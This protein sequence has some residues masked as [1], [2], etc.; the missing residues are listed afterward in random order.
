MSTPARK[1]KA[2][3]SQ[4]P[5][6]PTLQ[7]PRLIGYRSWVKHVYDFTRY[8]QDDPDE[9]DQ[10]AYAEW[11]S[12]GSSLTGDLPYLLH[13]VTLETGWNRGLQLGAVEEA[14]RHLYVHDV[15]DLLEFTTDDIR[16]AWAL[17]PQCCGSMEAAAELYALYRVLNGDDEFYAGPTTYLG[18]PDV[19]AIF[20]EPESEEQAVQIDASLSS[21]VHDAGPMVE[22][23]SGAVTGLSL[24]DVCDLTTEGLKAAWANR[25]ESFA[26]LEAAAETLAILRSLNAEDPERPS[27]HRMMQHQLVQELEDALPLE[28][29]AAKPSPTIELALL[30]ADRRTVRN[31]V[32]VIRPGQGNFRAKML[33]R[34]GGECCITGCRVDALI[35]A[36]HIIPYRGDQSDDPTNGL[37]LRVDLHR[38]FDAHLV[39]I[40]PTT[41]TVA[42]AAAL[43]DDG[44][45]SF[46]GKRL[47][48]FSPKPRI[49]F[50]ETHFS[51]FKSQ[52]KP[53]VLRTK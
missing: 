10:F 36:A 32:S 31:Q 40:D 22:F 15:E 18:H 14:P 2:K 42:V 6:K 5:F 27:F 24:A 9:Q 30:R 17:R 48:A 37:L 16:A 11:V 29:Q 41:L 20:A 12:S 49:L 47:F 53:G 19:V 25:P 21:T 38:L 3:P 45:Q 23:E 26:S 39:S 50:L 34:Y 1:P 28:L 44:Y 7:V 13:L 52:T 8:V 35:E 51:T 4:K 46:H 33:E 43:D